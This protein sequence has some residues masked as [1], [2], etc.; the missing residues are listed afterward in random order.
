[1][2]FSWEGNP[3]PSLAC[4]LPVGFEKNQQLIDELKILVKVESYKGVPIGA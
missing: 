3:Q 4:A 2:D 1:M